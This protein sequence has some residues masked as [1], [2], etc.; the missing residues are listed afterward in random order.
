MYCC[1]SPPPGWS[2]GVDRQ[3]E[4]E[5]LVGRVHVEVARGLIGQEYRRG[6]GDGPLWPPL[7]FTAEICP[8]RFLFLKGR[9]GLALRWSSSARF[10]RGPDHFLHEGDVLMYRQVG[11]KPEIWK[12]T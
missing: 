7:L 1:G 4:L 11:K 6:I 12:T 9:G 5:D 8:E 10:E 3:Q 2:R